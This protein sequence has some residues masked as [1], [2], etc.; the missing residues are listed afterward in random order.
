ML[1]LKIK[2]KEI[3]TPSSPTPQDLRQLQLS[4]YDQSVPRMYVCHLYFYTITPSPSHDKEEGGQMEDFM[5]V[6][7]LKSS[8]A[9]CLTYFYPL[10]G[11]LRETESSIIHIECNDE[12]VKFIEAQV[13]AN[14]E[15]IIF[16]PGTHLDILLPANQYIT[17]EPL[18]LI[19]MNRFK[20]NSVVMGI[21]VNHAI[22]DE[23]SFCHFVNNWSEIARGQQISLQPW[24]DRSSYFPV[25]INNCPTI[26]TEEP[27]PPPTAK[28]ITKTFKY[29]K[30]HIQ[31]LKDIAGAGVTSV[32]SVSAHLWRSICRVNAME[33][34]RETIALHVVEGRKRM[35]PPLP[36]G[37]I[38]NL[39][40]AA[41]ATENA[42]NVIGEEAGYVENSLHQAITKVDDKYISSAMDSTEHLRAEVASVAMK[43]AGGS[44]LLLYSS[45]WRFPLYEADFGWEKPVWIGIPTSAVGGVVILLGMRSGSG[46]EAWVTLGEDEMNKLES[47]THFN[48]FLSS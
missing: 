39:F 47:D 8:L 25:Q 7:G 24:F 34:D 44:H 22:A 19:Q 5:N 28:V 26:K 13:E 23:L 18:V 9:E 3:I 17:K 14:V 42:G 2:S 35:K 11:R 4:Y 45:W 1:N 46:I 41:V 16:Q 33:K 6:K 27:I 43:S 31:T 20:C 30:S 36:Q 37:F 21:A 48:A 12:G 15:D 29:T 10:A 40:L 32:E 38:G